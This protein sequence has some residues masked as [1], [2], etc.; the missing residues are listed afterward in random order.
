[1]PSTFHGMEWIRAQRMGGALSGTPLRALHYV[2]APSVAR[3]LMLGAL[4]TGA[5]C[6]LAPLPDAWSD[7]LIEDSPPP[8]A[9]SAKGI[10]QIE[11]RLRATGVQPAT[12]V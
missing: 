8:L 4:F 11:E 3:I 12:T 10:A 2:H 5:R 1:M 6:A 7:A 9:M